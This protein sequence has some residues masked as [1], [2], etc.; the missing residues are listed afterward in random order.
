MK[1]QL[2]RSSVLEGGAAKKP[3]P[4][5]MQYGE[6][7]INYNSGDPTIFLKD[8][9]NNIIGIE[10]NKLGTI[11]T[12]TTPPT[13]GNNIG[14]LFFNTSTN[15]LLYWQGNQWVS[16]TTELAYVAASNGGTILNSAGSDAILTMANQAFAGLMS[17]DDFTKLSSIVGVDLASPSNGLSLTSNNELQANIATTTTLGTVKIGSGINV[18]SDGTISVNS[19][20][21]GG[22][23]LDRVDLLYVAEPSSGVIENSGGEDAY[24]TLA[25]SVN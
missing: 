17:P 9:D 3:L 16:L 11:E 7:A 6:L 2:K 8:S 14:D 19:T 24:L 12:G 13:E 1:I 10:I 18:T 20:G 22:G 4:D 25:N 21:G 15:E 23:G 5:Q